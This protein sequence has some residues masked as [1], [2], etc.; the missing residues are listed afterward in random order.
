MKNM[1]MMVNNAG[2]V[3]ILF[4]LYNVHGRFDSLFKMTN[5]S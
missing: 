3:F 1:I 4:L 5:M 2:D